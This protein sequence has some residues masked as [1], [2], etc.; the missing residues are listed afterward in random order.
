MAVENIP[1]GPG[2]TSLKK[3]EIIESISLP[4]KQ[5]KSGDAYLRF[6]PRTEMDIAVVGVGVS[7]TLDEGG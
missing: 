7:V 4:K 6:I 5:P 1:T 3:G 2:K